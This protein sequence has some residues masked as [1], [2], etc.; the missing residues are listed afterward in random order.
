MPIRVSQVKREYPNFPGQSVNF[1]AANVNNWVKTT[2][3]IQCYSLVE[4]SVDNPIYITCNSAGRTIIKRV[5]GKWSDEGIVEG[6]ELYISASIQDL[7]AGSSAVLDRTW[8]AG[9]VAKPV[10]FVSPDDTVIEVGASI[11]NP[12]DDDYIGENI[13]FPTNRQEDYQSGYYKVYI[14]ADADFTSLDFFYNMVANSEK[15]NQN[16]N[17]LIDGTQARF[18]FD[19]LD[20]S[21]STPFDLTQLNYKS[22]SSIKSV[23][24]I[25]QPNGANPSGKYN[26]PGTSLPD[27]DGAASG[28]VVQPGQVISLFK[29][30]IIHKIWGIE[31]DINGIENEEVPEWFLDTECLT[32]LA[33]FRLFQTVANQN[34]FIESNLQSSLIAVDGNTGYRGEVY[35]GNP[36]NKSIESVNYYNVLGTPIEKLDYGNDTRVDVIINNPD[37]DA[38]TVYQFNFQY[39]PNNSEQYYNKLTSYMNNTI[40]NTPLKSNDFDGADLTGLFKEGSPYGL[41]TGE[42]HP[43]GARMDLNEFQVIDIGGGQVLCRFKLIPNNEFYSYIEDQVED[44]RRFVIDINVNQSTD[45]INT[46]DSVNLMVAG[47]MGF[48]ALPLGEYP[49]MTNLFNELP[50]PPDTNGASLCVGFPE[51]LWMANVF[52]DQD[53]TSGI[54]FKSIQPTIELYN[55]V[56]GQ[57]IE[58]D[59]VNINLENQVIDGL[60]VQQNYVYGSRGFLTIPTHDKNY[61]NVVRVPASDSPPNYKNNLQFGFRIRYEDWIKRLNIPTDLFDVNEPNDGLNNY[62]HW[63]EQNDWVVQLAI[64]LNVDRA[65]EIG[66]Y[67]NTFPMEMRDYFEVLDITPTCRHYNNSDNSSL[68][69]GVDSDT[70]LDVNTILSDEITRIEQDYTLNMGIF[71]ASGIY[72]EVNLEVWEG[73]GYKSMWTLSTEYEGENTNPLK[74]TGNNGNLLELVLVAPNQLRAICLL[75]PSYLTGASVN[76]KISGRIGCS[77]GNKLPTLPPSGLYDVQYNDKY[78]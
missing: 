53:V 76:Y 49:G 72:A 4:S 45:T 75:D 38:N 40:Q 32:D 3:Q 35:N 51:D 33:Q 52:F 77:T 14:F 47:S 7:G 1:L 60:G 17:S 16:L 54:T 50:V 73:G 9:F 19:E 68:Y 25:A 71:P 34:V 20:P 46:S 70:G 18:N 57:D 36:T 29:V 78:L 37:H 55:T 31:E 26:I 22:G 28:Q 6:S 5:N 63:L 15:N 48:E 27:I 21:D 2:F 23:K 67:K 66:T 43:S 64:Y 69:I 56:T 44:N 24:V 10:L 12:N 58:L 65:G 59:S 74:P 39:L 11:N 42:E 8:V 30:E 13:L 61:A 41:F 62:W